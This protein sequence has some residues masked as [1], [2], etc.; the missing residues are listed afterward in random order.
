MARLSRQSPQ[1]FQSVCRQFVTSRFLLEKRD[2]EHII[3]SLT[4]R[5]FP[6]LHDYLSPTPSYLLTKS[7]ESF[8]PPPP[9]PYQHPIELPSTNYPRPL[10]PGHHIIY[11]PT[12][13]LATDL[14]PDGTD[15]DDSPGPPF[16]RRL[17]AGGR[18]RFPTAPH[19]PLL[20]G[21]RAICLNQIRSIDIKRSSDGTPEKIFIGTEK[22]IAPL[23]SSADKQ[24][25]SS[26]LLRARLQT[27]TEDEVGEASIIERRNLVFLR[28]PNPNPTGAQE[29]AS[30]R[31]QQRTVA[32]PSSPT[33]SHTL[34][35]TPSLLFRYS[36]LMFNAHSI[37]LDPEHTR[38]VE[39]HRALLVHGPLLLTLMLTCLR[40]ELLKGK[41]GIAGPGG[42]VIREVEYRNLAPVYC[43]EEMRVCGKRRGGKKTKG[44]GGESQ[45]RGSVSVSGGDGMEGDEW[46]VWIE[47]GDGGLAVRGT[48]WTDVAG[49]GDPDRGV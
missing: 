23:L 32:P 40:Y 42:R 7:L 47:R 6:L 25:D 2:Q 29:N 1:K 43:G 45:S 18:I 34:T 35:P 24:H 31:S 22:R 17:W 8:L 19:R 46:E 16:T 37:H 28:A 26:S 20:D 39:G 13:T 14:L 12:P 4:Q 41:G 30:S 36:A 10:P 9:P 33:Y 11:F 27:A 21:S 44:K 5:Q 38:Q 49:E 3:T 48:V 15:T